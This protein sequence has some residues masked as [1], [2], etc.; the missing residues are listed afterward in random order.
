MKCSLLITALFL[1]MLARGAETTQADESTILLTTDALSL[2]CAVDKNG[3]L[4][5]TRF[6][7]VDRSW[8]SPFTG[9]LFPGSSDCKY[10]EAPVSITRS[11]GDTTLNL[12]YQSNTSVA[13]TPAIRHTT[14]TLRDKGQPIFVDV[15]FR[16][17]ARENVI[18]QW[19][20]LRNELAEP[21]RVHRLDSAYWEAPASSAPHLEW[22]DSRWADEVPRPNVEK[23]SKGRRVIENRTGNRHIEAPFPAF[24]MSF[25]AFPNEESTPCLF[26]SLAW[27]GSMAMSFDH[28]NKGV[29]ASSIGVSSQT[30][31]YL[32]DPKKS[33]T[34]PAC[35]FTYSRDG[36][37]R[38][39]RDF[40][41]W[42][43]LHGMRGGDRLRLV[44]NNSWEGCSFNVREDTVIEMIKGSAALGIELYVLDDG[45]FG[46]GSTARTGD[47]SGLGDW[48]VNQER[49]PNGMA[50][51]IK[52]AKES[53]ISFGLWFEPEMVNPRSELFVKHPEWVL[54]S[55]G[56]ELKLE[57]NQAVLDMAN[58][59]V[60]EFVFKTVDDALT[61]NPEMRFIKWD[62]NSSIHNPYSP[63]LAPDRQGALLWNYFENYYS[64]LDR[65][66]RNHPHVDFQACASGG[67]RAD[68]GAMRDSH[69]FWVSDNTNPLFRLRSQWTFSSFLPAIAT[70]CHVTHAGDFKPKF[71]FD[72]SMMGQL[73]LEVDPRRSEPE[74]QDAA[75]TGIAAYKE[76]REIVQFGHQY[77]HDSPF[78]STLPSLNYVSTDGNRAL[79]LAY[80]TG[81]ILGWTH[82]S[83]RVRG[84]DPKKVYTLSEIN[85][86]PGDAT[87]R[88]HKA[89]KKSASGQ[90]WMDD[91]IPLT[92]G[93]VNDSAAIV[94]TAAP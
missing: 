42:T 75:R 29:F 24:I 57:R 65:L 33:L 1:S 40:H 12:I 49:F 23:L 55:P 69:T 51:L 94:L 81:T 20:V 26:A 34:T 90:A 70:T 61:A 48:A 32:L 88:L 30:G 14:I 16:L 58:P 83:T 91:G 27:S 78:E 71:R 18:Q 35:I 38:A 41:Q 54:R 36:K 37:G 92:F 19:A 68:H 50:K 74:F 7:A 31:P 13:E 46:N 80:Q 4:N 87:Q 8:K 28:N 3:V 45:W 11:N 93:R 44:D 17:F 72:V 73:G 79:V 47:Y 77:R 63:H 43:R 82:T 67:G 86:P 56:Q 25:G 2:T 39:S 76:V 9:P 84:L 6:G 53:N 5:V 52:T 60:S 89:A 66:V 59:E 85:L 15:H 64:V 22:Y 21:I 10:H 62:C